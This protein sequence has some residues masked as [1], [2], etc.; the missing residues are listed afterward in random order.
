MKVPFCDVIQNMSQAPS[1][2]VQVLIREDKLDYLKNPSLDFKNS[3]CFGFLW[4]PS[5]AEWRNWTVPIFLR[6]N[7][8]N[9]QCEATL[10]LG[11]PFIKQSDGPPV[12]NFSWLRTF[13]SIRETVVALTQV[14]VCFEAVY[15]AHIFVDDWKE[16]VCIWSF[17]NENGAFWHFL[18][19]LWHFLGAFWH[20]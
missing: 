2:S 3:F 14:A 13:S 5:N 12:H 18:G 7:L 19:A 4:N 16:L 17:E 10:F 20:F 6:F 8:V 1:R 15:V 9:W 11:S